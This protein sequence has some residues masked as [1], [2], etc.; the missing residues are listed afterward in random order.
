MD[1]R[2]PP[3]EMLPEQSTGG[4]PLQP[5]PMIG[6]GGSG[7]STQT[8]V[9]ARQAAYGGQDL[10]PSRGLQS[11]PS[12]AGAAPPVPGGRPQSTTNPRGPSR[13]PTARRSR[14]PGGQATR[15]S[16]AARGRGVD[17]RTPPQTSQASGISPTSQ[18]LG[19][20]GRAPI[21]AQDA[22]VLPSKTRTSEALSS[23]GG[24]R[25]TQAASPSF[26]R[27]A[28][29]A[30]RDARTGGPATPTAAPLAQFNRF[31]GAPTFI[32]KPSAPPPEPEPENKREGPPSVVT[33]GPAPGRGSRP[34]RKSGASRVQAGPGKGYHADAS[35][36]DDEAWASG[37]FPDIEWTAEDGTR[38]PSQSARTER[39][40]PDVL[41]ELAEEQMVDVL[42]KLTTSSPQARE[43]LE[44]ILEEVER[45]QSLD[46]MRKF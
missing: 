10:A 41:Q 46:I 21:R 38:P 37:G 26:G 25:P 42:K 29:A 18:T 40:P 15:Q 39:P 11:A 30:R 9:L 27:L 16:L 14:T 28:P 44:D 35:V 36:A 1:W 8:P 12:D 43:L 2:A 45:L 23:A 32:Q 3:E 34:S 31:Q 13:A 17:F 33:Q 7:A 22:E 20:P 5:T 24:V 4:S 19:T 6:R